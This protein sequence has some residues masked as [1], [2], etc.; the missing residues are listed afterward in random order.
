MSDDHALLEGVNKSELIQMARSA[1]LGNLGRDLPER[2]IIEAIVEAASPEEAP[3]CP[4]EGR[5]RKVE[6]HI[7]KNKRRL[8]SQL[9]GCNGRCVTYGCPDVIVVRCWEGFRNDIL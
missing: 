3:S 7:E 9:P 6:R 2:E 8:L 5:R 4:L 1:G